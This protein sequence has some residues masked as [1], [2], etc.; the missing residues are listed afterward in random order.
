MAP[1]RKESALEL[2]DKA[3]VL[4]NTIAIRMLEYLS[5]VKHHVQGF[6]DLAMEFLEV[7]RILWAIE[8]G[9]STNKHSN[10]P[11]DMT[12]ELEKRFRQ[13]NDDFIVLNQLVTR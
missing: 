13:A 7:C 9:L 5:T 10:L 8:T 12:I 4:G 1:R 11:A 2:C 6:K 3:T